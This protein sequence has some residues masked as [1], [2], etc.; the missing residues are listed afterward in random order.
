MS[1]QTSLHQFLNSVGVVRSHF[2]FI[3]QFLEDNELLRICG[4]QPYKRE[5]KL[6]ECC[7]LLGLIYLKSQNPFKKYSLSDVSLLLMK[8]KARFTKFGIDLENLEFP[9]LGQ[10]LSDYIYEQ[11]GYKVSLRTL[12]RWASKRRIPF[13]KLRIINQKE[14]SRWLELASIANA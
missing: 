1:H 12:Y 13:S 9:L 5:V 4:V 10:E 14:L 3:N 7:Y 2:R 6:K 8:D 11:I